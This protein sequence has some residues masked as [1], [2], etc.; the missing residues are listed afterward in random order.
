MTATMNN[1]FAATETTVASNN[2]SLSGTAQ[3]TSLA[4]SIANEII[5]FMNDSADEYADAIIKSQ[6]D[7]NTMDTLIESCKSLNEYD[8]EFLK[9]LDEQ[10]IDGMLKSQQSKRSRCKGKAMTLDN[11]KSLMTA[12][13]AEGLIRLA[14]GKEKH[15]VGNR[16]VAGAIEFTAEELDML[17]EDQERLRKEIRNIQSKKSIMKSKAGFSEED[18][19]WQ[20]LLVVEAQLKALRVS[21]TITI[22][23]VDETKNQLEDILKSQDLES[24]KAADAK[25]LLANIQKLVANVQ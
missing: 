12:A 1:L 2:R 15:A 16:R 17:K 18:E 22:V 24:L 3:L 7:S 14:T 20:R 21:S 13:I 23:E 4:A 6:T 5:T 25:A 9:E 19:R 8:I 10:T 11:Y